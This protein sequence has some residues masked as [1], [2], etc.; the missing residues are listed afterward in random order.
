MTL[1]NDSE[2]DAANEEPDTDTGKGRGMYQ[3]GTRRLWRASIL[4]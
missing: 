1:G 4:S 2:P 3:E